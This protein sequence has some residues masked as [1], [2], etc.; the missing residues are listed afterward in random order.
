MRGGN[1]S[2]IPLL[3]SKKYHISFQHNF[4]S[5]CYCVTVT[6]KHIHVSLTVKYH[7]IK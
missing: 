1:K 4:L 7:L 2:Q 6:E 3:C 5:C